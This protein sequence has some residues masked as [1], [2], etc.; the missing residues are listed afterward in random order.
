MFREVAA[1]L[2][3]LELATDDLPYRASNFV[4]GLEAMPVRFTPTARGLTWASSSGIPDETAA[5]LQPV[6]RRGGRRRRP[7]VTD[8]AIPAGT[9][10]SNE[11]ILFDATWG[12]GVRAADP[13][14][15]ARIAPSG[16]Q[17]FPDDTFVRQHAVMHALAERSDVPMARVHWFDGDGSWFGRPF[18]LMDRVD[19]DIPSDNPPY[20]G[21]RLAPRRHARSSSARPGTPASTPWPASTGSTSPPSGCPTGTYPAVDDTARPST[22]TTGRAS[23]PGPRTAPRTRLARRA[24]ERAA[25]RRGRPSR[26]RGRAWS[27]ATPASATSSTA[28]SRSSPS[29]TGRCPASATRCSTSAGGCSPTGRSPRARAAPG[30]RASPR[31]AETGGPL[32]GGHRPVRRRPRLL[33]A[34][35]RAALHRHHA[36]HGQ[37][38]RRHRVR[39]RPSSPP[40][41]SSA[42]PSTACSER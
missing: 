39:A 23:S 2:P 19:G 22:S 24:L 15:V 7:V 27:G 12:D 25:A 5:T 21:E 13:S 32:G 9:G 6:A 14:L 36:A 26:P 1:R 18:W 20:A 40:T 41:T 28:T 34:L 38:A 37:A 11:T 3:D 30:S 31:K 17:V 35:R 29:S 16:Y 10:W 4:S 8:V 33:R 42:R